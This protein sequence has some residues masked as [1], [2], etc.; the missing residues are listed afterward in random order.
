[1]RGHFSGGVKGYRGGEKIL[2]GQ[3]SGN[4]SQQW[5]LFV[6]SNVDFLFFV[7]NPERE[8]TCVLI[9]PLNALGGG[10]FSGGGKGTE[11]GKDLGRGSFRVLGGLLG[12]NKAKVW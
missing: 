9:R 10:H 3:G 4:V 1:M 8:S 11:G 5:R 2:D 12:H 7:E 6:K